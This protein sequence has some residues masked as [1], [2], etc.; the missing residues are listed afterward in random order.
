L[1][2]AAAI[3]HLVSLIGTAPDQK[4]AFHELTVTATRLIALLPR[5]CE[6]AASI[7]HGLIARL[8]DRQSADFICGIVFFFIYI[9]ILVTRE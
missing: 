2:Q 6:S 3:E 1:P 9:C 4:P 7:H 8:L 5:R